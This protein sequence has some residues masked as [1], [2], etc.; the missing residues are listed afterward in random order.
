[1]ELIFANGE[2]QIPV[3][4]PPDVPADRLAAIRAAFAAAMSDPGTDR[5]DDK[6]KLVPR[7]VTGDEVQAL[8]ARVYA[9]PPSTVAAAIEATKLPGAR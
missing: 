5:G 8:I 2:I 1:M 9:T 7:L 3:L 6:L 4:M